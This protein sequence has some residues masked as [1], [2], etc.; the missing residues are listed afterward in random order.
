MKK[1]TLDWNEY[2]DTAV[3]V[4]AEGA[5]LLKN[6][7]DVL[8]LK[9]DDKVALFGRSASNYYKSGTGSGGMVNVNHVIDIPEGLKQVGV[10]LNEKLLE[11][12][13]DYEE[14][15]PP[16][17]GIGWGN[18]PWSQPEMPLTD[19][20]VLTAAAEADVAIAIIGRTAGEDR[21][22]LDEEGSYRL[23]FWEEN[24]LSKVRNAFSKMVVLLNVGNII[25]MSFVTKYNPDSVMYIWQGGMMGGLG[26]A[27]ALTGEIPPSGKLPDT[28]AYHIGDYPA[29]GNFGDLRSNTY[30]EGIYVGYRHF[31]TLA[32]NRVMYPFGYGLTYTDFEI[33][34]VA[35]LDE[36]RGSFALDVKVQNVGVRAGREV[37]QVYI[38]APEG[39]LD[40][41][42]R[43]LAGF[44][45]TDVIAPMNT[46]SVTIMV[47]REDYASYDEECSCFVL[48]AGTYEVYVGTD[49]RSAAKAREFTL[50]EEVMTCQCTDSLRPGVDMTDRILANLP[51][52]VPFTGDKGIKLKDVKDGRAKME[53]FIAQL[54]DEDLAAIVRGEGMG[55]AKVTPGTAS[56]FGGVTEKLTHY[57]IPTVCCD[58]G[59]SGMRLD[60]G[61]KAFSLPIGTL[62]AST[63]DVELVKKL[64]TYLGKEMCANHVECILGPGMNIHRHPL[65]GRNFEYFSEDSFLTG[66]MA[67]AELEGLKVSNVTGTIKHFAGNNQETNRRYI[68]SVIPVRALR[69]I[70]LKGF[71]M[72]VKKGGATS[73]M[74]TYGILNGNWTASY[75]D[76]TTTVLRGE[77]GFEGVVM[78]DWWAQ[79]SGSIDDGS[80]NDFAAMVRAQNDLY[81]CVPDSASNGHGDNTLEAIADG[82][83]TRGELQRSAINICRMAMNTNAMERPETK[84]INR[85]K[86]EE[87]IDVANLEYK[88][89]PLHEMID[90]TGTVCKKGTNYFYGYECDRIGEYVFTLTGSSELSGLA[91]IPVTVFFSN[92]PV[93]SF[94]FNGTEGKDVSITKKMYIPHR[95]N[96]LRIYVGGN[97]L[98]LKSLQID[99]SEGPDVS[100]DEWLES[101]MR[102]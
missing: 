64:Y 69:E 14:K 41:P 36:G 44:A 37:V 93:L 51:E 100:F 1:I 97:G 70:Y 76:L 28:I 11:I 29:A 5:V 8:P 26:V 58:D 85:P 87:D 54:D 18:E 35:Y 23:T 32:Q 25:D 42:A 84:I 78:T 80:F 10:S 47:N 52:E 72:A 73:V 94:T 66:R 15:N 55:S 38:K 50:K 91:Q 98:A 24:M 65:N 56:A 12:Y 68:D 13:A 33:T 45:K 63:F 62:L 7:G 19:E 102:V 21:D 6:D 4:I 92:I 39:R 43:V 74:T 3:R 30:A 75:Y 27:K 77:W 86:D 95:Y 90:L 96:I 71:E 99:K 53:D 57:G 89:L 49:V 60:S 2:C 101:I 17:E 22:S 20:V 9:K 16:I 79:I 61:A 31:E 40:K 81:M 82:S 83:L 34:G 48:E 67:V 59:P 46:D 88:I